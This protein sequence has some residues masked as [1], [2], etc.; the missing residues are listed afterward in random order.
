MTLLKNQLVPWWF[1]GGYKAHTLIMLESTTMWFS[2][3]KASF[4]Q[5]GPI[6]IYNSIMTW[7][8]EGVLPCLGRWNPGDGGLA[9]CRMVGPSSG[10]CNRNSVSTVKDTI[11]SSTYSHRF[12]AIPLQIE[13]IRYQEWGLKT[14]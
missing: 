10:S 2:H 4:S 11:Q 12:R 1:V 14:T 8:Q 9:Q 7:E 13:F 3:Q 6:E 5:S